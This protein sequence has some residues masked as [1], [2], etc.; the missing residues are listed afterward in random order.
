MLHKDGRVLAQRYVC[1]CRF[2]RG[3]I[4][5]RRR[6]RGVWESCQTPHKKFRPFYLECMGHAAESSSKNDR[7][8]DSPFVKLLDRGLSVHHIFGAVAAATRTLTLHAA[9]T[10]GAEAGLRLSAIT[11]ARSFSSRATANFV[12]CLG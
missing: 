8:F 2:C 1:D 3:R 5:Q 9:E 10:G 4:G 11:S 12:S 7:C 6:A